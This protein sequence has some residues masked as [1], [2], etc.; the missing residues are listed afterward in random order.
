MLFSSA[1]FIRYLVDFWSLFFLPFCGVKKRKQKHYIAFCLL[2]TG[3][4]SHYPEF[5]S[6]YL[7]KLCLIRLNMY[8]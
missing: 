5:V 3:P 4:V 2:V 7:P 1:L 6:H 8:V